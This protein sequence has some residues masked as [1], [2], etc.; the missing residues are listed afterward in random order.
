VRQSTGY[1]AAY[2]PGLD[3][4]RAIGF[5]FVFLAHTTP[6]AISH[7]APQELGVTLFFFLSGYLITTLLRMELEATGGIS[8]RDFYIRRALR[9]LIPMYVAFVVVA[10]GEYLLSIPLGNWRGLWSAVLYCYNYLR[11]LPSPAMVPAGLNVIWSLC[12]EEHFYVLFPLL[13]LLMASAGWARQRQAGVLVCLCLIGLCWRTYVHFHHFPPFWTY[14]T[15]DCRFDSLLWGC[16][17]A[18][19]KNPRLDEASELLQRYGGVLAAVSVA[20]LAADWMVRSAAYR[21]GL[22]YTVQGVLLCFIF[23]FV[24]SRTSHWSVRWL[25]SRP[26]RD[27]GLLSYSLYLIHLPVQIM[28]S[29]GLQRAGW[30]ISLAGLVVSLIYAAMVRRWIELPLKRVRA[31]FRHTGSMRRSG[32][33]MDGI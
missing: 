27:V 26:L 12:V 4:L 2:I 18:V 21:E 19:W 33:T 8:L 28:L 11:L 9:I 30:W 20:V 24:V 15:T 25:E 17:L 3:G 22:R 6:A 10:G 7:R 29:T 23:H 13:Y 16:V 32:V 1:S 14:R 5:L 31:R